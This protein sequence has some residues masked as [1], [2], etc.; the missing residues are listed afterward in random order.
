MKA[1]RARLFHFAALVLLCTT[2]QGEPLR[3]GTNIWPGYE[4][5]YLARGLGYFNE[6]SVR[7]VEFLSASEVLRAFRNR[8]I[9]AAGLTLDEVLLLAEQGAAVRVILVNDIS[10]GA[11]VVS[12]RPEVQSL[13]AL[14]R[15]RVGVE[16]TALGAYVVTRALEQHGLS[17]AD[18]DVVPLEIN[19]HE[20]A[21]RDGRVDAVVTFEPVRTRL[22]AAGAR[23]L[24][25]SRDIPGEIVDVLVVREGTLTER[26]AV[27]KHIV[28]GWFKALA[29]LEARPQDAA[30]RMSKRLDLSPE[31]VLASYDGL[32]LPD[33]AENLALLGGA[34]PTLLPTVVRLEK[35]M[36]ERKLLRAAV[37]V[38]GLLTPTVLEPSEP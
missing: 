34:N 28:A 8:A 37:A 25:T 4:P 16:S 36:V 6:H 15:R 17:P 35:L 2:A 3:L 26:P 11:D 38:D 7:L 29:H 30:E 10:N 23:E 1:R 9:D 32:R 12:S 18:V 27:L 33:R 13:R 14:S 5:L 24:F 21:Y 19:E 20:A 31:E 22:L